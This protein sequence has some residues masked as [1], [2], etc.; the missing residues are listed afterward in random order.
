MFQQVTSSE[1]CPNG[2]V[3]IAGGFELVT[4]G[5]PMLTGPQVLSSYPSGP[6][7]V[8]TVVNS[9]F[10]GPVQFRIHVTCAAAP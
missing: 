6:S 3:A 9:S 2:D 1:S 8:L 10:R 7:W 5:G 4:H